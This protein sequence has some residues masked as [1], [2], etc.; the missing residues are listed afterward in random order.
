M[1][2]DVISEAKQQLDDCI[3]NDL[4]CRYN[5]YFPDDEEDNDIFHKECIMTAIT[6]RY[7]SIMEK[8]D[9]NRYHDILC[10]NFRYPFEEDKYFYK[11]IEYC[12]EATPYLHDKDV[13]YDDD[14]HYV[15][16][17]KYN[18]RLRLLSKASYNRDHTLSIR[19]ERV[20]S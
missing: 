7:H 18:Q 13:C 17:L 8:I 2:E 11:M 12:I 3:C 9:N 14:P 1:M 16:T 10:D 6:N 20:E 15:S 5:K 4:Y 19:L